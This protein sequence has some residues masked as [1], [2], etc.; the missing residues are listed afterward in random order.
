MWRF[1]SVISVLTKLCICLSIST[2]FAGC[3]D[4]G[5]SRTRPESVPREALWAGGVDGGDWILCKKRHGRI[6]NC[7]VFGETG[8]RISVGDYHYEGEEPWG[9]LVVVS[10]DGEI[11][12]TECGKL[13]PIGKHVYFGRTKSES[14]V[15]EYPPR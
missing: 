2:M 5:M 14:W 12:R 6:Y 1:F 11:I 15:V 3:N 13:I 10:H 8:N 9:R 7:E 4:S